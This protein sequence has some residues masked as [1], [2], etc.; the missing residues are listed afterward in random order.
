MNFIIEA[1]T[2]YEQTIM[3]NPPTEKPR[4]VRIQFSVSDEC[5]TRIKCLDKLSYGENIERLEIPSVF[6]DKSGQFFEVSSIGINLFRIP[7]NQKGTLIGVSETNKILNLVIDDAF[8]YVYENALSHLDGLIKVK[9][10]RNCIKI[11]NN[12]FSFCKGL[13]DVTNIDNVYKI[14][15]YAF[16]R[17]NIKKISFPKF[18][19]KIPYRCFA[20][21]E[22]LE[23][24]K[25]NKQI[26]SSVF[27]DSPAEN[28]DNCLISE[29]SFIDCKNLTKV[30]LSGQ[31]SLLEIEE[32]A[33]HNTNIKNLD[34]SKILSIKMNRDA[35][36]FDCEIK[37]PFYY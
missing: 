10:P 4:T 2:T 7:K 35:C 28:E 6:V 11:P 1:K 12:C 30:T 3:K 32:F 14:G 29:E 24:F 27:D 34:L 37:Y 31:I 13:T 26:P 18:C 21:C 15:N 33:F 9:W 8:D 22:S 23:S 25:W 19:S 17:T 5:V 20:E 16:M 36:P